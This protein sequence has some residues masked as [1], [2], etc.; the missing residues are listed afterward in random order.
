MNIHGVKYTEQAIFC[1]T[2]HDDYEQPY[3]YCVINS[4][5]VYNDYEVFICNVSDIGDY[6]EHTR[7][8]FHV[9]LK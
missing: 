7:I 8:F 1:D 9:L 2:S 6:V 5:D 4:V 3:R